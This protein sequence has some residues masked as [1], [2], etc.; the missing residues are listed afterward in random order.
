MLGRLILTLCIAGAL[1]HTIEVR[2]SATCPEV[3]G[4]N[5]TLLPHKSNCSK[6]YYCEFGTPV[7][8]DC[9]AGLHFNPTLSVCDWPLNAGCKIVELPPTT[10]LPPI[11]RPTVIPENGKP[12]LC[13]AVD[14]VN[15]TLLPHES[16]CSKFYYCEFGKPV[17]F[18]CPAGLH[19]NPTLSVCDW[20]L[21]A[22]CKG[23]G[24]STTTT[25]P[26]PTSTGGTSTTTGKPP[27]C[28][29]VDGVNAT[30]L[31]HE[32]DC[33]KFYYCEFGKPV[34]FNCPAGLHFN[35]T[36]SVCDWPLSAGCKGVG[37][38]TTTT[39]PTP[40]STGGTS[41]TTGKP[42]LCPAVDGVNATLLPHESDCSKFYYCEFG[43]PVEFDCPAGLHFNPTLSVCD[44][45]LSA[46]CKGVGTSTTTTTPTPTSTGG[47]STTTG[48]PPLCPAVD[49]VNATLLP[50]E[51]DCSK[52]YYCEFGK[53]V[54]FNCPAG[55][56]FNPTLS[57]CDWPL[58]AGCKGV[59]TSTTS[60]TPT[61]TST[62]GTSTTTGKPPLCPAVDGVNATLLPHESDCSKFYYCEFGKPVEFNCPAGLH[63]NPTLSVCD[64]PLSAGC[65][66]VGTST[67]TTTPTPTSTGG[68]STTTGKPP[69]CPA[70]D[71]VNATLL[72]HES[73]CSKFYYCE[74]GKPV[75]FD[76]P[77]GLHFN[78]TLSVCDWPLSAGC[79]GVGTSTTT[80]TPTPTSTGGTSTTTGKPPLC[81]AV[82]GV[83]AT[84][85]PHESD[86][87]KFYYCE[88]G[89]PVEFNCPAGLHFNPT[90]SVCDWPL[91][92][93]CKGV[94]TSTTTTTPT[95]TST[96]GTS[97]TTGKP[98]L[99][100][101]VDGVN[102]TLLPHESDCSKFYY[103]EF[104]KPVE[105]NCPAGLHFNPTLSVCDWPLS[106]G[107][108]GV[109]TSTTTTTP[110]PTSTGGTSTTTGK[111][112]L[113]PAVDGVN[114]TLLP[115]ESD[116]S[117]FYY[118]E[119]G[120]P[121][122][123]NCP[124]GLHFNPTL[125]VCDWPLSAGCKGVGTS[126]TTT[127]PTPT[128]TGGTSTTTGKPPLC[129]AVD[130]VNAT[131]LPHESD[132]SKFYYCEFGKPVEFNC[133]AGLHFNPTL[134]VC[135]WPLS[136]G[137]KGVGTST[138]TTTPT[139]TSTGGTSTTTGK[140]PLCPAVDG[141]NAT[142]L[143]HESDCSKFYYCEF[144]KPV[145]FN[146]PAGLHFNP[147][148][149]V[150]DWP[151]SAGCKGVG[152]S[153]TTTTPTPTSTGGT[154]TTT[155]KPPLCPAVDGVNATLLPHESDCSKFYYCEF[156]KPVEFNCPAGLHFNPTLSVCDWPLSAGCKGVG[157]STTTTTPTPTSTTTGEQ[158]LC[159]AV[160]GVNA[161][162]LPHESDCSKFYYCE[163]GKPVEFNC[164]A[165]LHFNPILSVCDWPL[166][167]GCKGVGTSTTTT[168]P[169]PT[170]TG[171][172]S[173]TTGEQPLCPAVDGVNATLLPHESDC[174]KFY[175][176]EFGKPVEFNCPA[177]LHFNPTLS[178]CDWP[179]SAGC[180]GVGTSTTT[181]TPTST[182]TGGTS[183]TTGKPPLC[184]AVDGVNATLLPHESDCSKFY[185]C[186]FGK[187][188]EFNC[189]AG[190][191]FNP[192]L[193]VCD[194]PLSAG[195][196]TVG[197]TTT[198]PIPTSTTTESVDDVCSNCDL[199]T[200]YWGDSKNCS[201]YWFCVSGKRQ[202]AICPPGLLFDRQISMCN[203]SSMVKC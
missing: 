130:G 38:S 69:L 77:A 194:W 72:P 80:T 75:E 147:T 184:P 81:P 165:G 50:H 84:L 183:T 116:C 149:S 202:S 103:C 123:F 157:T 188:V 190:L 198:T 37:T 169:T 136:A 177:G 43:K 159:P 31:P 17:E 7:E 151:L 46:G 195:C 96:G 112:P 67:T 181:T 114:A 170:S 95:P 36:L 66:G 122:E 90:L 52:F 201:K 62:G 60:T 19:F 87:S 152:T 47:T 119:F 155:G 102:A 120:K 28:P 132:C 131:L 97:T 35:P 78:P 203:L 18:D 168:T 71:G 23:V 14:G 92:A 5:A 61:P 41:T 63:F 34:E 10:T 42:P 145:E 45:P 141:V 13:P 191:H 54:E 29:A 200:R 154:S 121:V 158:P 33:S 172:T 94:G 58:S 139:P 24:T 101:A 108:K 70:V 125:S 197:T 106:A 25:T 164:P 4:V 160:D 178:V 9:P 12:P 193:S 196:K 68:T 11:S 83:N 186:E 89:K 40:T 59:G 6:F 113:C 1:A 76:C 3:D 65:K 129:P 135:D 53:P 79:K 163:F 146:C 26:T 179:L 117:K 30:L 124:A 55:L 128:S 107:C 161:T 27:L 176:C 74:F 140:P 182:S 138:T 133:P 185:Y 180:K 192:I 86:C 187:P 98:P 20:P 111:P 56:H 127:T 21:S 189:P 143:P 173:T 162:L 85:L 49:G 110:T 91:S 148:L 126:T 15:A 48:K 82:D 104:G 51:S 156:G 2:V 22:G 134:S 16:D 142:L 144:G 32:S 167:A 171:G 137:C 118:C 174:S 73:D 44:W 150:C 153:T 105:F 109:G 64:W 175:Y 57:V 166:S 88:F 100:P 93:G 115:H 39:T 199:N 99:C 8:F